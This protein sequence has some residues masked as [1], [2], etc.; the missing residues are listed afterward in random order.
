MLRYK[1][2]GYT[3]EIAL[4]SDNERYRGIPYYVYIDTTNQKINIFYICG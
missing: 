4:P 3:I 2:L 1:N